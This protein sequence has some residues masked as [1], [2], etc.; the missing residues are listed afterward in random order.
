[1]RALHHMIVLL[2]LA[3]HLKTAIPC[4]HYQVSLIHFYHET[5]IIHAYLSAQCLQPTA[6]ILF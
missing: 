3:Q 6:E 1:M 5:V 2:Q 4:G